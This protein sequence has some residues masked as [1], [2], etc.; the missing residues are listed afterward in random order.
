MTE[1]LRR[2]RASNPALYWYGWGCVAGVAICA[3]LLQTAT[4]QVG[5]LHAAL[6]PLK[7][8]LSIWIAVW[9]L[10]WIT[11]YL[12]ARG[13]VRHYTG[14]TIVT[15][16]IELL[17]ICGQAARGR[18]SHFNMDTPAD[19]ALF[20]TMGAAIT[21]FTIWTAVI[22]ARFFRQ[23]EP[24]MPRNLLWGIRLGLTAFVVFAFEGGIM[25]SIMR[26]SVG[27]PDGPGGLPLLHWS[28]GYG[29]LRIAHFF[30]LHSLQVLPLLGFM[31]KR[32]TAAFWGTAVLYLGFAV[33][34]L[35]RALMG[36]P[37]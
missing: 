11:S 35:V 17:I 8:F 27:G 26:H 29:D 19:L 12:P 1:I 32:N 7:F 2:L 25:G 22:A 20:Y 30:G 6:K 16:T 10:G 3:I 18:A 31:I 28:P 13:T 4:L 14:S 24:G 33:A 15:M 21:A 23:A 37:L 9:T 36:L 34:M 5:G